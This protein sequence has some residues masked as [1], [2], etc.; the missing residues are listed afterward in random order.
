MIFDFDFVALEE[1]HFSFLPGCWQ[2]TTVEFFYDSWQVE[3]FADQIR[4]YGLDA[5]GWTKM[6]SRTPIRKMFRRARYAPVLEQL[7]G[8][9][10][11]QERAQH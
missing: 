1:R 9:A 11:G 4:R 6:F 5:Q 8:L 7:T 10:G 2:P 3:F